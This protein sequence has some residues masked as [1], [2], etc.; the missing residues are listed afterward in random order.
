MARLLMIVAL[1]GYEV[2]MRRSKGASF[3]FVAG[4]IEAE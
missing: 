4:G 3:G 2:R 1:E